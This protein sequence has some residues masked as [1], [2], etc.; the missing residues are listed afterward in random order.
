MWAVMVWRAGLLLTRPCHRQ[1]GQYLVPGCYITI[2]RIRLREKVQEIMKRLLF[3]DGHEDPSNCGP[4]LA[5]QMWVLAYHACRNCTVIAGTFGSS[6][7]KDKGYLAIYVQHLNNLRPRIWAIDDYTDIWARYE[8]PCLNEKGKNATSCAVSPRQS[9]LLNAYSSWL[10]NYHYTAASAR[11]WLGEISVFDI[12]SF[13]TH[14]VFGAPTPAKEP[15][16]QS[17]RPIGGA[18]TPPAIQQQRAHAADRPSAACA[19][20]EGTLA[21]PLPVITNLVPE[22]RL[23][24]PA[25]ISSQDARAGDPMRHRSTRSALVPGESVMR[26]PPRK[27]AAS[28]CQPRQAPHR[29]SP[30]RSARL[31]SDRECH[32]CRRG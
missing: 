2:V 7:G 28:R 8:K 26:R 17:G 14:Q 25:G 29:R 10:Y 3:G 9:T 15:P 5:A 24:G 18:P 32:Q 23:P 12:N 22:P 19:P 1:R 21:G 31:A 20:P 30:A 27:S 13:S 16:G 6:Q 4:V 11:I